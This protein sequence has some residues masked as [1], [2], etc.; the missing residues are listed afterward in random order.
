MTCISRVAALGASR[1]TVHP[2]L[3]CVFWA[4]SERLD[5]LW[6]AE[7]GGGPRTSWKPLLR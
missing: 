7:G 1:K 2:L 6:G 4:C 3:G 5:V